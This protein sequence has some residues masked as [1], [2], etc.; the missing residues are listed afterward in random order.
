MFGLRRAEVAPPR[1]PPQPRGLPGW[2]THAL[3]GGAAPALTREET[4]MRHSNGEAAEGGGA[5]A[6]A[7]GDA[8]QLLSATRGGAP[9][10]PLRLQPVARRWKIYVMLLLL[11]LEP[12]LEKKLRQFYT[13]QTDVSEGAVALRDAH[14]RQHP[15]RARLI[16]VC[17]RVLCP[18]LF[19]LQAASRLIF[20]IGYI[21][22][23]TPYTCLSHRV[24]NIITRR[25]TNADLAQL[26]TS[27]D[28]EAVQKTQRVLL[29]ARVILI[30][31]FCGFRLLEFTSP[32]GNNSNNNNADGTNAEGGAAASAQN[33]LTADLPVPPPPTFP[34]DVVAS[35]DKAPPTSQPHLVPP[36]AEDGACPLC[37]TRA[38]QNKTVVT[39][40][41]VV[42]CFACLSQ[43]L[44]EHRCCPV[45]GRPATAEHLRRVY[46]C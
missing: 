25:M 33:Y 23:L 2:L 7:G 46:E 27:Q 43:Y 15:L 30:G 8:R 12:Y 39:V 6:A 31:I 37:H 28:S 16:A 17:V 22:E 38:I 24:F 10:A 21:V 20:Q 36:P 18:L 29:L 1:S 45:S 19:A 26:S 40:S 42:G 32:G 14:A 3:R 41:G 4:A 9:F 13:E 44:R 35:T 11:T 5:A 34:A